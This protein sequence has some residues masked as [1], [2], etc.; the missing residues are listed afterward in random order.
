MLAWLWFIW[1]LFMACIGMF[2]TGMTLQQYTND[3]S[4]GY[5]YIPLALLFAV[6]SIFALY[7]A[8]LFWT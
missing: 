3:K 4:L 5:F 1:E 6:Y 8:L 7:F 2:L